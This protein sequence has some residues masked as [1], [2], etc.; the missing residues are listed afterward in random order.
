V[1]ATKG[2]AAFVTGGG[3]GIGRAI[4][5]AL[6]R[7]GY[8]I[9]VHDIDAAAARETV[10]QIGKTGRQANAYLSDVTDPAALQQSIRAAEGDLSGIEVLVNNAGTPSDRCPLENVTAQM[11]ARSINV[12][13]GG[14][15]FATQ[16]VIPYM[17]ARRCGRIINL[18]SLQ[19]Q[20]GWPEGATYNAAKGAIIAMSK[21]WALEFAPWQIL[22]NCVAPGHTETA[23]TVKND[24][25]EV[26]RRKAQMIPL[27]R[28]ARPDEIAALV[29]FLASDQSSFITGQVLAVNGGFLTA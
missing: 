20:M 5:L 4:C 27:G 28:Y 10:A 2:S 17:K 9:A 1:S 23:M 18:G 29:S 19:G 7:D 26:R 24:S 16:A 15:L 6:A 3:G 25:E 11:L 22:V 8:Q 13:V 14:T 12:H 21:G